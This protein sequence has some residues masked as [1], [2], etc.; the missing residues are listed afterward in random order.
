M[1]IGPLKLKN[2][3]LLAP[4]LEPNDI[5]F[6]LLCKTAG[7]ALTYTGMINPLSKQKL[8]LDDKPAIQLFC[9]DPKGIIPFIKKYDK[10]VVL[11][12]FNLGCPSKLS[13]RLE[14]GAFMHE[15][16]KTI[17]RILKKMRSTTKKPISIKLRKSPNALKIAKLAEKYVDTIAIH[18]RTASQG[19][20]GEP[21]LK[22]AEK[23]KQAVSVPVIYS[24]N[25]N[26]GNAKNLLKKFDFLMVGRAA[27]GDPNIFSRLIGHKSYLSFE[28][29]LKLAKKYKLP[30]RQIK[31]QAMNFTKG[32][33]NA[34][35]LRRRLVRAKTVENIESLEIKSLFS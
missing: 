30:F 16:T 3:F 17:E 15:D 9:N 8:F 35:D 33:S 18:P 20:S 23:I 27:I 22:F 13:K 6:R 4:M 12:D 11:W 10:K 19:Y 5:A 26:E 31:M 25:V 1:E 34:K 28:D 29:Y 21:D 7:C 24:G 2:R 32:A 14:H